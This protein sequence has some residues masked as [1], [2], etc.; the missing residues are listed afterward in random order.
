[1]VRGHIGKPVQFRSRV[2]QRQSTVL[3]GRRSVDR[4][5]PRVP[6]LLGVA[7]LEARVL[8]EHEAAGSRPA[9]ETKHPRAL[10]CG[11]SSMAELRD[12]TP[13]VP[14]RLLPV[15]PKR[16]RINPSWRN[17][18]T[19]RS[20]KPAPTGMSVRS[21]PRGPVKRQSC[22][23]AAER[24]PHQAQ[25]GGSCPPRTTSEDQPPKGVCHENDRQERRPVLS[26]SRASGAR[27]S[28]PRRASSAVTASC[29]A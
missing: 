20:Q 19:H 5:H 21:G 23:S 22:L 28:R 6:V 10:G 18:Q 14:V 1:V 16:M 12:V 2:A 4:S 29:T 11:R 27:A 3:I 25:G 26:R 7:Q 8:R 15:T 9:T 13:P 17:W 24:R